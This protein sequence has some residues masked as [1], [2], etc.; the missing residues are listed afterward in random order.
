MLPVIFP[1][2]I[3][4]PGVPLGNH[5]LKLGIGNAKSLINV[6]LLAGEGKV[7]KQQQIQ[8]PVI[9]VL[10]DIAQKGRNLLMAGGRNRVFPNICAD[11]FLCDRCAVCR[12]K[13][14]G[15]LTIPAFHISIITGIGGNIDC[16]TF[17]LCQLG[18]YEGV[19]ISLLIEA[20]GANKTIP[21][22]QRNGQVVGCVE[23]FAEVLIILHKTTPYR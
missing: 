14:K 3:G 19:W 12:A 6:Q 4:L 11:E 16:R 10:G 7:Q 22:I 18:K 20:G 5:L 21:I 23:H 2:L 1:F 9:G 15:M 13:N 8:K 17:A